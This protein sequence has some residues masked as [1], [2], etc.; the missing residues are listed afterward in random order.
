MIAASLDNRAARADSLC[1]VLAIATAW[2]AFPIWMEEHLGR[3]FAAGAFVL[4]F[5]MICD[6]KR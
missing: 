5:P 6:W 4:P 3:K 1:G 2:A